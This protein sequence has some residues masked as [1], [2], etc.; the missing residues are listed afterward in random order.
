MTESAARQHLREAREEAAVEREGREAMP[1]KDLH[2][3]E[4][5][6][7]AI[8][9]DLAKPLQ[10]RQRAYSWNAVWVLLKCHDQWR[11]NCHRAA[12]QRN[13]AYSELETVRVDE[14]VLRDLVAENARLRADLERYRGVDAAAKELLARNVE[15]GTSA[16][17]AEA[18]CED[19]E[20]EAARLRE[21]VGEE[22]VSW[23]VYAGH[24]PEDGD[25][26]H[27]T[28]EKYARDAADK[29]IPVTKW[30]TRV[31]PTAVYNMELDESGA[32]CEVPDA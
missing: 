6:I 1:V 29:G 15:L 21:Q 9:A 22:E 24:D 30:V 5:Q 3:D 27:S 16:D 13:A 31:Y 19:L 28:A 17:N 4:Q 18:K 2:P 7:E 11:E 26:Y 10:E 25:M 23:A 12:A 8:R 14:R 32:W 20:D